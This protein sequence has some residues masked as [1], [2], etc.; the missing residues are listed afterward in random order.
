MQPTSGLNKLRRL[1]LKT[2]ASC[3]NFGIIYIGSV[4]KLCRLNGGGGGG[5]KLPVLLSKK[6][7]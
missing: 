1:L 4:H 6:T 3:N 2:V 7:I 5:Q